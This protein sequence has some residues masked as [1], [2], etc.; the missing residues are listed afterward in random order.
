[1]EIAFSGSPTECDYVVVIFTGKILKYIWEGGIWLLSNAN[2]M[3]IRFEVEQNAIGIWELNGR[4]GGMESVPWKMVVCCCA[5]FGVCCWHEDSLFIFSYILIWFELKSINFLCP[6]NWIWGWVY[7]Q[8]SSN[9]GLDCTV[10][11][12]VIITLK[13]VEEYSGNRFQNW[14]LKCGAS[15]YCKT[16]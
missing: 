15:T 2:I 12:E 13:N 4:G 5:F 6:I 10:D 8:R 16:L 7:E 9:G 11:I 3:Y 14:T 1:M